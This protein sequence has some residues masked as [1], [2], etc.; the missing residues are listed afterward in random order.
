MTR[1]IAQGRKSSLWLIVDYEPFTIHYTLYTHY[2]LC[3][4]HYALC[5]IHYILCT[6]HYT[7]YTMD[8][9]LY[10]IHYTLYTLL[11]FSLYNEMQ[12]LP[13]HLVD[14][15]HLYSLEDFVQVRG[16]FSTYSVMRNFRSLNSQPIMAYYI[17][18]W[19]SL[20]ESLRKFYWLHLLIIIYLLLTIF[21][22]PFW[23][24]FSDHVSL[25]KEVFS[26][27]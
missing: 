15:I 4:I 6:M 25:G 26:Y 8:Y 22:F 27:A 2:T 11:L 21:P 10:T 20:L 17:E 9:V 16:L 3:T 19:S 1:G 18:E 12:K 23:V 14:E 13:Q 24:N 5:T 7:L